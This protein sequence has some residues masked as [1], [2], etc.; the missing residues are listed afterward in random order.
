MSTMK[1]GAAMHH[2]L[3]RSSLQIAVSGLA[4]VEKAVGHIG[5]YKARTKLGEVR[6]ELLLAKLLERFS[7]CILFNNS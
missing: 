2:T 5:I 4:S 3:S 1:C 6:L 7:N